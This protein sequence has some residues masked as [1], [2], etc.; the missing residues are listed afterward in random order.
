M[1]NI[2]YMLTILSAA[3]LYACS[4]RLDPVMNEEEGSVSYSAK[5]SSGINISVILHKGINEASGNPISVK[6]FMTGAKSK[7]YASIKLLNRKFHP[8]EDMMLHIDWI[9]PDGNSFFMKRTDI[10]SGDTTSELKS[11]IS[12]QPGKRDTG[13]YKLRVY[14]FRELVAENNFSLVSYNPDSAAVFSNGPVSADVFL[15]SRYNRKN[16]M[17]GDTGS[18]FEQKNKAKVYAGIR[19]RNR[20]ALK[21]K[22]IEGEIDWCDEDRPFYRKSIFFSQHDTLKETGSAV[23]TDIKSRKPG[24]YSVKV[25]LY[26]NLVAEKLFRLVPEKEEKISVGKI[27][28]IDA[29]VVLCSK[30]GKKTKK[31]FGISDWFTIKDKAVVHAVLSLVDTRVKPAGKP[32]IRMEWVGPDKKSFYRKRFNLESKN[33]TAVLSNSISL[34]NKR[35]PGKYS[36][37]VY[38]SSTLI[39]EKG[40]E[41]VASH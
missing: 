25:Y 18:V 37:R 26:N 17:P 28:G 1:K 9:D 27:K 3:L 8:G 29:D 34:S 13:Q 20:D 22:V 30:F 35:K 12:V 21:G 39:C 15:G 23:S 16:V 36:C 38:Y 10:L 41:L 31:A 7:V 14:L 33:I 40:F 24:S 32:E 6:T 11:A 19:L 2:L 4:S 5:E